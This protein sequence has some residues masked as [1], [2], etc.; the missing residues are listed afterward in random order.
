[1]ASLMFGKKVQDLMLYRG[2]NKLA[3][4]MNKGRLLPK[5]RVVEI[6]PLH[7]GKIRY[8]GKFNHGPSQTNTARAHHIESGLYGGC[9][10]S[11]TRS[12]EM[13]VFFATYGHTQDG[14]VF[15][16]DEG[17]LHKANVIC[18]EFPDP[19]YPGEHEVTLIGPAGGALPESIIVE[20]YAVNANGLRE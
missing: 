14:Y 5:G 2:V 8:D 18:H 15:V 4:E 17:C 13:A 20:K 11:T 1:M 6:V 7:D 19:E 12:E 16:I 9:G 3:D 10:V